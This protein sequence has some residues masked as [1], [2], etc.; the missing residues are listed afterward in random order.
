[1]SIWERLLEVG[2]KSLGLKGVPFIRTNE[3]R[4]GV[5][6]EEYWTIQVRIDHRGTEQVPDNWK[7]LTRKYAGSEAVVL[8]TQEQMEK[9]LLRSLRLPRTREVY[10]ELYSWED[11]TDSL[12]GK[13]QWVAREDEEV[14]GGAMNYWALQVEWPSNV[15]FTISSAKKNGRDVVPEVVDFEECEEV[16]LF[17]TPSDLEVGLERAERN[18]EDV[19][20]FLKE[21]AL[22]D[23]MD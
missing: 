21:H 8:F 19:A 20:S 14:F 3:Q 7:K 2:N 11:T 10:L 23:I 16:V 4:K 5:E 22:R 9:F 12:L 13:M 17:L 1:M 15:S 18:P 6:D